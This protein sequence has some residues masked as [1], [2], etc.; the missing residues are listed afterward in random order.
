MDHPTVNVGFWAGAIPANRKMARK[1]QEEGFIT[2]KT[3]L[4]G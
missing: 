3:Q 4:T 2:K 1:Q